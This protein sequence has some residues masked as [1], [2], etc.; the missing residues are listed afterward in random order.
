[1]DMTTDAP[2]SK[3]N[4]QRYQNNQTRES[5]FLNSLLAEAAKPRYI[6]RSPL[7]PDFAAQ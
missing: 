2:T 4:T 6:R 3:A 7:F 5:L 1:M